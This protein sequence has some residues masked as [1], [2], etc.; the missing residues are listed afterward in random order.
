[1]ADEK[2]GIGYQVFVSDGGEEVGAVREVR[3]NGRP[4]V[5][6]YVENAGDFYVPL[7]AIESVHA[8]KVVLN[9]AKLEPRMRRAINHAHDAEEP[10][11]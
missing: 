9:C 2:I 8:E 11:L 10:G 4:E 6:I 5:V 3:P 1:M 7:D